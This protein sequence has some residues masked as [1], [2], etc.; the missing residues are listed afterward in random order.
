MPILIGW[1]PSPGLDFET[2][3]CEFELYLSRHLRTKK[4]SM[5]V[6]VMLLDLGVILLLYSEGA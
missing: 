4:M 3:M 2:S 5:E 1:T 6:Q